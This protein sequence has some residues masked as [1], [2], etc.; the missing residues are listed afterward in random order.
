MG[1]MFCEWNATDTL[2]LFEITSIPILE[3]KFILFEASQT[4]V[5]WVDLHE[6]VYLLIFMMHEWSSGVIAV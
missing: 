4:W 1:P 2:L 3:C 6:R 5:V